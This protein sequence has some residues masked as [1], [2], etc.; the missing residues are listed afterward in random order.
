MYKIERKLSGYLL[1]FVGNITPDE[2]RQWLG[3]ARTALASAASSFCVIVDMRILAPLLPEAQAF[4][5][6]GQQLFKGKG[7]TRSS[8]IVNNAVT[9]SQFKRL[10]KDSGIYAWERYF[11]GTM[12]GCLDAAIAWGKDGKDPD[13]EVRKAA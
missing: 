3:E 7:M 6:Q 10:A 12:P 4:M 5:V 8:V 2:M 9:A 11:D 1:T 13:R